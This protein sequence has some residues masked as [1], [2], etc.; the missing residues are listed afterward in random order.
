MLIDLAS[1][2]P[3]A[4]TLRAFQKHGILKARK[5]TKYASGGEA[6]ETIDEEPPATTDEAALGIGS[7][8][9]AGVASCVVILCLMDMCNALRVRFLLCQV[10]DTVWRC[11]L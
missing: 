2:S 7:A 6:G 4:Y 5:S 8:G 3:A 11:V 9:Y 10:Y 1:I